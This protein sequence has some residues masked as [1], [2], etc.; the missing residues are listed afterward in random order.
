[1]AVYVCGKN[2]LIYISGSEWADA[3]A[4][5]ISIEQETA[6]YAVFGDTAY[7]TCIGLY[8]W[9]GSLSGYQDIDGKQLQD[10]ATAGVS[11]A[12]LIYPKRTDLTTYYDGS[13]IFNF[14]SAGE[15]GGAAVTANASFTG[16]GALT[17]T[18]WS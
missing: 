12:L 9:S 14:D 1:M 13:A 11:V 3:N 16:D 15:F 2:G 18:G 5:S 8:R 7:R 6:E 17:I 10:A 4:W